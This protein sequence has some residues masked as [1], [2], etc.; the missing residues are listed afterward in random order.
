MDDERF[1]KT[2]L[3]VWADTA[4]TMILAI[5]TGAIGLMAQ[6]KALL[7]D[8]AHSISVAVSSVVGLIKRKTNRISTDRVYT[9]VLN[10]SRRYRR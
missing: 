3:A 10:R 9:E 2:E 5:I 7:A 8:S 1:E 4:V 6:S